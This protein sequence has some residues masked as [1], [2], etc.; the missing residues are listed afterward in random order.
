MCLRYKK[1][2]E[3]GILKVLEILFERKYVLYLSNLSGLL[4]T[5]NL[6]TLYFGSLV[7]N[8]IY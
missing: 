3:H 2:M 6:T 1:Y 8:P 5:L 7:V 4:V